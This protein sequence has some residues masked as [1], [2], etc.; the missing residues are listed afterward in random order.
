MRV[1]NW[2]ALPGD[3]LWL[4]C[5]VLFFLG[6]GIAVA[7]W[8]WRKRKAVKGLPDV[9]YL[10][11]DDQDRVGSMRATMLERLDRGDLDI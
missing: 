4:V 6:V 8:Q 7:V 1:V 3:M 2:L 9:I 5:V 11:Y 10:G